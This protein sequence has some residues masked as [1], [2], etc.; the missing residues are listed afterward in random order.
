MIIILH[1]L[2]LLLLIMILIL[3][4]LQ[5]LL[6]IMIIILHCLPLMLLTMLLI[7]YSLQL[8]LLTMLLILSSL[9]LLFMLLFVLLLQFIICSCFLSLTLHPNDLF[10]RQQ[11]VLSPL[12]FPPASPGQNS[13]E[14]ISPAFTFSLD[15][16]SG[17]YIKL[18]MRTDVPFYFHYFTLLK[19]LNKALYTD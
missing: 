4:I 7:Q 10:L 1:S 14:E 5:L 8:M 16:L 11:Q 2:Q 12:P 3:N 19:A 13:K 17:Q 15:L 9:Q 18:I 6:L